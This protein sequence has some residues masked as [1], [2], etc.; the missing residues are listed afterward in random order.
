MVFS[1]SGNSSGKRHEKM[2]NAASAYLVVKRDDGQFG[3]V[4]SLTPG[5]RYTLGRAGTNR[6][7]L[8][9][10]LCSREH[11]EVYH[12]DGRWRLRDLTSLNGTRLNGKKLEREEALAPS[13][14][15]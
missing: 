7:V 11:A 10:E 6:I 1:P 12:A 15:V 9:D 13:D 4:Y 3:D 5:Q 8:K 2:A 14:E